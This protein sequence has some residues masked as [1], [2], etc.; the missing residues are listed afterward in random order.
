MFHFHTCQWSFILP[1]STLVIITS[2]SFHISFFSFKFK[3]PLHNEQIALR[4]NYTRQIQLQNC[5]I[6]KSEWGDLFTQFYYIEVFSVCDRFFL[7]SIF[8][9]SSWVCSELHV[10]QFFIVFIQKSNPETFF[11]FIILKSTLSTIAH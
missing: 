1:I 5:Y 7:L 8:K 9:T 4:V 10:Q 3:C 2:S 6:C 11:L